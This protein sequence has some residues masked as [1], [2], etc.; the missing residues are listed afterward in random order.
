MRALNLKLIRNLWK[1][2][3][4]VLA[5]AV[6]IAS[7]VA[8]LVMSL[9]A[10]QALQQTA[11]AYYERQRFAD[12]FATVKRAPRRLVNQISTLP[13][14]RSVEDRIKQM[15]TLSIEGF[16]EPV[17][18]QLVSIPEQ[19]E[20]LLNNLVLRSGRLVSLGH[21]DEVVL[22]EPFAEAHDLQPGDQFKA[23]MNGHQRSLT[24]VGI[25]LSPEFIYSMGPGALMPDDKRFGVMW[26][27]RE[28][29]AAAYDLEGAFNEVRL[30][31]LHDSSPEQII[32]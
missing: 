1:L 18:G 3:G 30:G 19:G 16:E 5:I 10:L 28:A 8:V 12:V 24:V 20:P 23:L 13:G 11:T 32:V 4:Q 25:A 27:G 31:L 7:G 26:M 22:N 2:K 6:V 15:A 29:L 17:I 9:S 14:V 21:P